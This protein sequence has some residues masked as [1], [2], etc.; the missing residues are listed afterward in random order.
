MIR[1][2]AAVSSSAKLLIAGFALVLL[3]AVVLFRFV[4]GK[5]TA[6]VVEVSR[7]TATASPDAGMTAEGSAPSSDAT[8]VS[9]QRTQPGHTTSQPALATPTAVRS[10]GDE[11]VEYA[12]GK[13]VPVAS[14]EVLRAAN[15]ATDALIQDCINKSG[16]T[17]LTGSVVLTFLVARK[18]EKTGEFSVAVEDHGF[19]EEG[20]TIKNP[21]LVDCMQKTALAMKFPPNKSP[22]AVAAKR[23][24][25]IANNEMKVNFVYEWS[26]I[27]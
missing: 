20:N 10:T 25:E 11:E 8:V 15:A 18:R 6:P 16:V 13:P 7:P 5:D 1:H 24:V 22:I 26:R 3:G 19:E 17:G 27:R 4:E 21:E 2:D 9:I 12:N 14:L 23:R